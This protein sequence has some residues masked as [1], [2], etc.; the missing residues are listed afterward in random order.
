[1]FR[2]ERTHPCGH[3]QAGIGGYHARKGATDQR[4]RREHSLQPGTPV[5]RAVPEVCVAR[6]DESDPT[7]QPERGEARAAVEGTLLDGV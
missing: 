7:W 4:V 2:R 1:M 3:R 5:E 6:P